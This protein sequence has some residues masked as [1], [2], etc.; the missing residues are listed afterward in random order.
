MY[1]GALLATSFGPEGPFSGN[2][3]KL[4]RNSMFAQYINSIKTLFIVPNDAHNYKSIGILKQLKFRQ[5]FL[6]EL[7]HV[8]AIV[9]ILIVLIFLLFYNCVHQLEQ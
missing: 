1:M 2:T 6:R 9:G 7:K 3:P 5:L 8:G 4:L